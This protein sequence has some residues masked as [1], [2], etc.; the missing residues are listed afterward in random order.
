MINGIQERQK[1]KTLLAIG[2]SIVG[3]LI[4]ILLIWKITGLVGHS[5]SEIEPIDNVQTM[6]DVIATDAPEVEAGGV[7]GQNSPDALTLGE[8]RSVESDTQQK[9]LSDI[10]DPYETIQLELDQLKDKD[11]LTTEKY[12]GM[13]EVFTPDKVADRLAA[14]V[15]TFISKENLEDGSNKVILH[16]CTLDYNKMQSKS[17]EVYSELN[18]ATATPMPDNEADS[19]ETPANMEEIDIDSE[20]KK[21]VA[22]GVVTGDFEVHYTIPIIVKD[23]SVV[24]TEELKQAL[25]GNWYTGIGTSLKE[26]ECPLKETK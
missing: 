16:I 4:V 5:S 12:F 26:V 20:V 17:N 19:P 6:N 10:L 23:G 18:T 8:S 1:L 24:V 7:E 2:C 21:E 14:T 25:T 15:V 9:P 13:S 3:L 22:K 11:T